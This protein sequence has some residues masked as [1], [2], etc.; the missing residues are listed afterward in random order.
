MIKREVVSPCAVALLP[1]PGVMGNR[2]G[3]H[4]VG[5]YHCQAPVMHTDARRGRSR[6]VHIQGVNVGVGVPGTGRLGAS[7]FKNR[8]R[9][10]QN[11]WQGHTQDRG[12][13][14]GTNMGC[15]EDCAGA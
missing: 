5:S 13:Q 15:S 11:R 14:A 6:V 2:G 1:S 9:Q 12:E 10:K 3:V 4:G 8:K 7:R